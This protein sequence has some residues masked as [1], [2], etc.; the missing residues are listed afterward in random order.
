MEDG[1]AGGWEGHQ[2]QA[3][4]LMGCYVNGRVHAGHNQ[5]VWVSVWMGGWSRTSRYMCNKLIAGGRTRM[6]AGVSMRVARYVSVSK[7]VDV[8]GGGQHG[9]DA[10][11]RHGALC[12][13]M[14]TPIHW[15]TYVLLWTLT[16][17]FQLHMYIQLHHEWP[18]SLSVFLGGQFFANT[19]PEG[20][21]LYPC[22]EVKGMFK[23]H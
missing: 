20:D 17:L 6:I 13:S 5:Q 2:E 18:N 14:P 7:P 15:S 1:G 22:E 10:H 9:P 8:S 23:K 21:P 3:G 4:G 12:T 11:T 19:P 16:L